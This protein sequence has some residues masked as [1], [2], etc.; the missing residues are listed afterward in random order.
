MEQVSCDEHEFWF[1]LD[2]FVYDFL[3]CVVEVLASC[4]QVVLCV[5][6]VEVG[7]VDEAEGFH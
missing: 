7:D 2:G 1:E 5:A 6:E 3:E 4:F